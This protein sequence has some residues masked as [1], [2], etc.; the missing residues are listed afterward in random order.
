MPPPAVLE[1]TVAECGHASIP[2]PGEVYEVEE[3]RQADGTITAVGYSAGG[4]HWLHLPG[5]ATFRFD[6]ASPQVTAFAEPACGGQTLLDAFQRCLLPIALQARG[7][8]ALHASSVRAERGVVAFCAAADTG[9]STLAY[10][11]SRRGHPLWGD[12]ALVFEPAPEGI[13]ALAVPFRMRMQSAS[14]EYFGE[15]P[16]PAEAFGNEPLPLA[17]VCLL[18]RAPLSAEHPSAEIIRLTGSRALTA[19]MTHAYYFDLRD[20]ER[21]ARMV[22]HYLDLVAR[23]PV[24]QLRFQPGFDRFPAVLDAVER[25]ILA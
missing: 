3:W 7:F 5:V 15:E 10:G 14:V 8:E 25:T 6:E 16:L 20:T 9:K 13:C 19:T 2:L 17:A 4:W 22:Q 18:E 21:K 23:V 1:L 24:F 11:L 12:D